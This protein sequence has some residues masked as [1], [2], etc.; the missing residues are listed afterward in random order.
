MFGGGERGDRR[1][2]DPTAQRDDVSPGQRSRHGLRHQLVETVVQL[3][4]REARLLQQPIRIPVRAR[5]KPRSIRH[6]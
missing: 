2:V 5:A 1:R 3:V 4:V 6:E